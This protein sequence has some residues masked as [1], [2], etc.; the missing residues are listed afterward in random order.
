MINPSTVHTKTAARILATLAATAFLVTCGGSNND[1][2]P[3]SSA[4]PQV[5]QI[6]TLDSIIA[7]DL[8][9]QVKVVP[10]AARQDSPIVLQGRMMSTLPQDH[11]DELKAT[12]RAGHTIVLLDAT[13]EDIA[14]LHGII[15]AGVTYDSKDAGGVLAYSLRQEN[16]I[17]IATLLSKVQLSPLQTSKGEPDPTG[18]QDNKQ[19]HKKAVE[20]A[21][22]ELS[23]LPT[24][25]SRS[26]QASNQNVDWKTSPVQTTVFQ[27]NGAAGV[28]NTTVNVYALHSCDK[29]VRTGLTSDY[30]MV[31]ALADWTATNAK[32][33]SAATE[34]GT[35]SMYYDMDRD[36]Y[37]VANWQD[38]P[39]RTYCS[40]PSSWSVN[41]D[42]CRYINYPLQYSVEMTPL[43]AG[44]IAQTDAKPPAQ[45]GQA[46][47]YASGFSFT[48]GGTVNVNGMGPSA[49]L[50]AGLTWN[51]STQTT[52]A[53]VELDLSQTTNQG[54]VWTYRYCTGGEEPDAGGNCTSH[55]QTAKDVCRAQLGDTSGTNPQQGQRPVG[56][57]TDAVHTALWQAGPDTRTGKSTFDINVAVTPTIG[58]TTAALWG[59]TGNDH[60]HAGC[61]PNNC[62][63]VSTTTKTPLTIGG[64]Y[65]FKIPLPSTTCQ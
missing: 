45:Q 49:G 60:T 47:T 56:A 6:G 12:Y 11:S 43:N 9:Q 13:M 4:G 2:P 17:P 7:A 38:D 8:T 36:L 25:S 30:Y 22:A 41:A 1:P 48:L 63:C 64:N 62:D 24:A 59:A 57:F 23:R 35:S 40:S 54:A 14:A 51:N 15:G 34:L 32:F 3:Q 46:T 50:S 26:Q 18:L 55:V 27:Q 33:Q 53:P 20:L 10:F 44:S 21:M 42:I 52:V 5:R 28:Y 65:I 37:V 31:T 39:Q 19:A 61:D 29:D 16:R 58:Y